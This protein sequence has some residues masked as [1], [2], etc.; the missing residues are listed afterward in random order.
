MEESRL[1]IESFSLG[2]WQTNCY[3]VHVD[4]SPECWIVDVGFAPEP[5][6]AYVRKKGLEPAQVVLTHAHLDHVAGLSQ[7]RATW[8]KVPILIHEVEA[9][10]PGDPSLNLSI[11]L[12]APIVAPDPTGMLRH[13]QTLELSG[14]IF[15]VRHTPG[16]SPGGITLYQKDEGVAIVG[17]ALFAGSIGRTDFPTSD[18]RQLFK[19]IRE[20]LLTLPDSTRVLAGHGPDTTIGEERKHNPY[21]G[22]RGR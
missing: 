12:G 21:I 6:I 8:P 19:S 14:M 13:G 2:E 9:K 4:G 5:M 1:N 15:E 18:G 16:H 22:E 7:V 10:F 3:V 17:D 20:Q 11:L